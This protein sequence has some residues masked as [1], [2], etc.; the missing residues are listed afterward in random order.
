MR[1]TPTFARLVTTPIGVRC[2]ATGYGDKIKDP[3]CWRVEF[4]DGSTA[5]LESGCVAWFVHGHPDYGHPFGGAELFEAK[6]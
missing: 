4:A 5:F 6:P 2:C 1:P 3:D